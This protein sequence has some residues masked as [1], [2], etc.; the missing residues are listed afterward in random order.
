SSQWESDIRVGQET[1]G[2]ANSLK[3][4]K[5]GDRVGAVYVKL[6][7][8]HLKL[9][10]KHEVVRAYDITVDYYKMMKNLKEAISCLEKVTHLFLDIG[11]LNATRGH[12]QIQL[13][14]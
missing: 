2:T 3:F 4:N 5:S 6:A 11:S 9:D 10:R 1:Q 7:S 12:Y 13:Y 14:C 8:C